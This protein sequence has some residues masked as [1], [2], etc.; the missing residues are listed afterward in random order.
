M[1]ATG[2]LKIW[3]RFTSLNVKKVLCVADELGIPY[4]RIDAGG[5]FGIVDTPAF[6]ALNPNGRVPTI[7]D[8][9][10]VLWESNSIIRYLANK[11]DGEAIYPRD[12]VLR[13]SIDRW[14]DW[15][16]S[17]LTPAD[18]PVFV[19]TIRTPP[20]KHDKTALA[21]AVK[22]LAEAFVILDGALAGRRFLAIN[23]LSIAD[24]AL[25]ISAHRF[26]ANAFIERP[27][28]PNL[29]AWYDRIRALPAFKKNVD[30]PLE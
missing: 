4:D 21:P 23:R 30:L 15:Q 10:F 20:E 9:E 25:G 12:P 8:G 16:L 6:R 5:K 29:K 13:G 27:N 17:T 19:G 2:K 22:R 24:L 14:L 18:V 26:F 1:P 3:G 28:L 11:H 7:E